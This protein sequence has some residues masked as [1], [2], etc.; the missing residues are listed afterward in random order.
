M[1]EEGLRR[2]GAYHLGGTVERAGDSTKPEQFGNLSRIG[3]KSV[4][5]A[6]VILQV[7]VGAQ[8]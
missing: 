7:K 8:K 6:N 2:G 5:D 3:V 1:D 4:Q